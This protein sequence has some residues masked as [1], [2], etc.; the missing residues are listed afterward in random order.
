MVT[1]GFY[2]TQSSLYGAASALALIAT[3]PVFIVAL[4]AERHLIRG[5]RPGACRG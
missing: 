3:V 4:A 5:L 1:F 2:G